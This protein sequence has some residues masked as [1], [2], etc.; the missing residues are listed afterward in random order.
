MN[1]LGNDHWGTVCYRMN[2]ALDEGD[3]DTCIFIVIN[4]WKATLSEF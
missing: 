3:Y 2:I 1:E 4:T